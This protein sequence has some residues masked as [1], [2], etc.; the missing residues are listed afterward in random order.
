MTG[1]LLTTLFLPLVVAILL[2]VGR[3]TFSRGLARSFA[4]LGSLATL[5]VSLALVNQYVQLPADAAPR[6]PVQPR[7]SHAYHW[8]SYGNASQDPTDQPPLQFDFLLGVDGIS[9]SLIVL[10][11]LLTVSSVLI[12]WEASRATYRG[13]PTSCRAAASGRRRPKPARRQ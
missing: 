10:T 4:L 12:S 3:R 6:S 5:V 9:L 13:L 7:F 2:L 11:T 8:L 1:L